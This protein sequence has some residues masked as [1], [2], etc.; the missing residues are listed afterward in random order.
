MVGGK[1]DDD[2]DEIQWAADGKGPAYLMQRSRNGK[3]LSSAPPDAENIGPFDSEPVKVAEV[4]QLLLP[5]E[6]KST[7]RS[8]NGDGSTERGSTSPNGSSEG[9]HTARNG[10][11][12]ASQNTEQKST[13]TL[14][15]HSAV[16]E[17]RGRDQ[18][19]SPVQGNGRQSDV[20]L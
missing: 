20:D 13:S 5:P 14:T 16:E 12:A 10:P 11:S 15:Q 3:E 4:P 19:M 18:T 8:S 1:E 9:A 7:N 2:S 6:T 17:Q